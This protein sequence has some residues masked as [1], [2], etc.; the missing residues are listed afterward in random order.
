MGQRL[1]NTYVEAKDF[2]IG[3]SHGSGFDFFVDDFNDLSMDGT[4]APSILASYD[5]DFDFW[6]DKMNLIRPDHCPGKVVYWTKTPVSIVPMEIQNRV[7]IRIPV[8]IDGKEIMAQLDTGSVTSYIT[9]RAA[10]KFLGIDEKSA[11]MKSLGNIPVNGMPGLVYNYP[12]QTL[13]FGGVTVNRPHIQI[14]SDPVWREDDLLLGVGILRQLH[15]YIA[16]GEKKL[17]ITPALAN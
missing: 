1:L 4:L 16:Y 8:T 15:L 14:V 9:Q 7:H 6:H 2:V 11:G 3:H 13:T 12:F 5:V 17:Y 10:S